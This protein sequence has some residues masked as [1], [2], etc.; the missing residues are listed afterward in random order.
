MLKIRPHHLN[1]IPRF[2]GIGYSEDFCR[3]L[4]KIKKHIESGEKYEIVFSADD[5]CACCPNLVNGVCI[6]EEKVSRYDRLSYKSDKNDISKICL[7]CKW[8]EICRN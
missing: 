1:C 4:Y 7:D 2:K 5:V 8:Y 3:N 6:D